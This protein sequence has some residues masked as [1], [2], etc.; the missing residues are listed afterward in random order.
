MAR[1]VY[2]TLLTEPLVRQSSDFTQSCMLVFGQITASPYIV[3]ERHFAVPILSHRR[4]L[5]KKDKHN[6]LP[7]MNN[8]MRLKLENS[9]TK[10]ISQLKLTAI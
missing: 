10:F 6:N 8:K 1:T 7:E 5:K 2:S 3:F 4:Q 9:S